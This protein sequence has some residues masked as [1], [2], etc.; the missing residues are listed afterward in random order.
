MLRLRLPELMKAAKIENA[1]QLLQ[2]SDGRLK[3]TTAYNLV[4]SKGRVAK[5]ELKT[6]EA[7]LH[8]F[9][10]STAEVGRLFADDEK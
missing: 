4:R 2:R 8:I 5:V 1:Y 6:I 9:G 3:N 7:L 10:L